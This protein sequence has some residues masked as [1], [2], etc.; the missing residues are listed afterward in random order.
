VSRDELGND[1]GERGGLSLAMELLDVIDERA[2]QFGA[3]GLDQHGRHAHGGLA[4]APAKKI[5]IF[6][7]VGDMDDGDVVRDALRV[8]ASP[9]WGLVERVNR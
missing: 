1:D 5:G 3:R 8:I 9:D 2:D 6:G 4:A 7:I